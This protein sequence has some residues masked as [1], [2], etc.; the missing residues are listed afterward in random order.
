MRARRHACTASSPPCLSL[1]SAPFLPTRLHPARTPAPA[2][3]SQC[4]M[5]LA[6]TSPT[7][8]LLSLR[9]HTVLYTHPHT[10]FL[11]VRC[12]RAR[13]ASALALPNLQWL[14]LFPCPLSGSSS[15][16]CAS[17]F[18]P[19]ALHPAPPPPAPHSA[20]PPP[21]TLR[22]FGAPRWGASTGALGA[23]CRVSVEQILGMFII[24]FSLCS[25]YVQC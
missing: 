9:T 18:P 15:S 4:P 22:F 7:L 2:H 19:P 12:L 17:S 8:T 3:P 10:S 24:Y 11:S 23:G 21:P 14:L 20:A 1:S 6:A 16:S 25:V 5:I 13:V